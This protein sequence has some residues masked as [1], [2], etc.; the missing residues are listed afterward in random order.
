MLSVLERLDETARKL[1]RDIG[2]CAL[3]TER[4]FERL[5][6]LALVH[7]AA[8]KIRSLQDATKP[9]ATL[10]FHDPRKKDLSWFKP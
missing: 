1:H 10:R 4:Y 7:D 9:I 5:D 2:D 6:M 3:G 8:A